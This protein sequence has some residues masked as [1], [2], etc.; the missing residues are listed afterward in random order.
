MNY[1]FDTKIRTEITVSIADLEQAEQRMNDI[2]G[3]VI[4]GSKIDEEAFY[5][6]YEH[7]HE[8]VFGEHVF[9]M[10]CEGKMMVPDDGIGGDRIEVAKENIEKTVQGMVAGSKLANMRYTFTATFSDVQPEIEDIIIWIDDDAPIAV[11]AD[12]NF[13]HIKCA[14]ANYG[15]KA[16]ELAID[17]SEKYSENRIISNPKLFEKYPKDSDGNLLHVA[18]GREYVH[19][20]LN[21]VARQEDMLQSCGACRGYIHDDPREEK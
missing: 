18:L 15:E 7:K 6:D 4:E 17:M 14:E 2:C 5:I 12:A 1:Q 8:T 11:V 13:W 19:E 10:Y 16:V 9:E 21:G 3:E 20:V